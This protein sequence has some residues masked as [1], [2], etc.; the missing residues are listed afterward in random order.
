DAYW[1]KLYVDQPAG[2]PL[3]Y[4]HALRDAPEEVPSFRLGQHLYGTY[5]TRLHENNWICIQEDTGLL[6]LNRSLDHSSWEKLSVRTCSSLKPRE[7]CFP[8]TRPSFR[9]RENRP[10]GTFHQFR[11]L[12]VQFLCPNISVAYRLLEGECRPCGAAPQC[13]LLLVL[14]C[15]PLTQA[16]WFILHLHA[17]SSFNIPE[18]PLARLPGA[19]YCSRS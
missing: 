11:L 9:I 13:L 1:E 4:V 5:R 14:L 6:Y 2:T 8:E 10:P 7:L 18:V 16:I 12:P 19:R 15:E 17:I 3:L